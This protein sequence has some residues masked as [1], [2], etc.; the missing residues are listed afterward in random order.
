MSLFPVSCVSLNIKWT[1]VLS[2]PIF[3]WNTDAYFAK[4]ISA[5]AWTIRTNAIIFPNFSL[6]FAKAAKLQPSS[7]FL[8]D[9]WI[10]LR[11]LIVIETAGI[12]EYGYLSC[13]N[14]SRSFSR[15]IG[16]GDTIRT[17]SWAWAHTL[18]PLHFRGLSFPFPKI[19][20][21]SAKIW[22]DCLICNSI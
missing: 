1:Y 4:K 13:Q 15:S 21:L 16:S 22:P 12:R 11:I 20:I 6:F 8:I 5:I 3:I 10:N 9:E 17:V 2:L 18:W 14:F 19:S 7:S